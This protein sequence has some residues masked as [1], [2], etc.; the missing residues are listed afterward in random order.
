M[1][2]TS[3]AQNFEDVMLWRALK[4]VPAGRYIDVGAQD[5]LID[6][7]SKAF[8]DRGWRGIHVEPVP[9]YADMLRSDRPNETV[10][11]LALSDQAGILELSVFEDTGLSTGVKEF[12]QSHH[13][14]H[15]LAHSVVPTP[16]LPMKT[17]FASLEGQPVHWLKIDVEGLEEAVLRGWD[18]QTLRPWIILIEA[19]VPMSTEVRYQGSEDILLSAGYEFVYFDGLN[20]FY[21][22]AEH[23]ELKAAFATPPNVFDGVRL[24]GL[25]N[26][27]LCRGLLEQHRTATQEIEEAHR[28][29]INLLRDAHAAETKMLGGRIDQALEAGAAAQRRL[30]DQEE[31]ARLAVQ[32]A[33][34]TRQH[35]DADLARM[36][37]G[38]IDQALEAG[39]AAQRRLADQEEQARLAIQAAGAT[40]QHLQQQLDA[41][42]NSTSWR[43]TAPIRSVG[44]R[45]R[46]LLSALREGRITSGIKRRIKSVLRAFAL[47]VVR[48]PAL[49]RG[50]L[51]CLRLAPPL[52]RRV[53]AMLAPPPIAP[54]T[55]PQAPSQPAT[56]MSPA[57]R[58]VYLKLKAASARD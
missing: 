7:V 52:H 58:A 33:V 2:F 27:E 6:S 57:T 49:K 37:G 48:H 20:R 5:P 23:P 1:T 47:V 50:V 31:Q 15:G 26:S 16:M 43:L 46:R 9:R 32:A 25:A 4:H 53:R 14:R 38:R 41:V 44:T 35:L 55:A 45:C 29:E 34:A 10:L 36:L 22:A 28:T 30:A 24:S 17:A 12:A 56:A 8:Y 11:Q 51:A 3:Y 21:V 54:S 40:Q 19:T 13:I 18:S 39:A 42:L